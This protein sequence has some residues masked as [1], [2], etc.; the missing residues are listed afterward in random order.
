MTGWTKL[1]HLGDGGTEVSGCVSADRQE[2]KEGRRAGRRAETG[3]RGREGRKAETGRRERAEQ[4]GRREEA[5]SK[6]GRAAMT[7]TAAGRQRRGGDDRDIGRQGLQTA[8]FPPPDG[9]YTR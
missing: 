5:A 8:Y 2:D 6:R 7:S 1:A 3:R 4:R 9:T